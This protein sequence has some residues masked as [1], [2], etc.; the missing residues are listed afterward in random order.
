MLRL[1]VLA[2][3]ICFLAGIA[4][5]GP[6]GV[7]VYPSI[8]P[9]PFLSP[10]FATYSANAL[11]ALQNG[12]TTFGSPTSPTYY[13][14]TNTLDGPPIFG[15]AFPSWMGQTPPPAGYAGET[16]NA[17]FFGMVAIDTTTAFTLSD[18]TFNDT[19]YG[20]AGTLRSLADVGFGYRL[21]GINTTTNTIYDSGN[22]GT[23]GTLVNEVYFSGFADQFFAATPADLTAGIALVKA[24]SAPLASGT[25]DLTVGGQTFVGSA[26]LTPE[27]GTF[28][29][30]GL[31]LLLAGVL[32]TRKK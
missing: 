30:A 25:F 6:I 19:F 1:P 7:N 20:T 8:G 11:F 9:D 28:M 21:I 23:P 3:S 31:G 24:S 27:P 22:P 5:A 14:Q 17:L 29:L 10:S 16:G 26:T 12:L 18:V 4:A 2:V 15:T 13:S 32:R